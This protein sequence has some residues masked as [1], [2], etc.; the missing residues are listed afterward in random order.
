MFKYFIL[1]L[2]IILV[3]ISSIVFSISFSRFTKTANKSKDIKSNLE[4]YTI[5]MGQLDHKL[6]MEAADIF[7]EPNLPVGKYIL[8]IHYPGKI[9][10]LDLKIEKSKSDYLFHIKNDTNKINV[11]IYGDFIQWYR[12]IGYSGGE[13]YLGCIRKNYL[14][15]NFYPNYQDSTLP[16]KWRILLGGRNKTA[17]KKDVP[18]CPLGRYKF[19][20]LGIQRFKK[21]EDGQPEIIE[22]EED[23]PKNKIRK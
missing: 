12:D 9:S 20:N 11:E 18:I 7:Y 14:Y 6:L 23:K 4:E 16:G 1:R 22:L 2:G 15:G 19:E 5:K 17:I 3:S 10:K 8:E 13:Y 21:G